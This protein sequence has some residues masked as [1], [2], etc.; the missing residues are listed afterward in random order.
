LKASP[1]MSAEQKIKMATAAVEKSIAEYERRIKENDLHRSKKRDGVPETPEL[2]ALRERR[3]DLRETVRQMKGGQ[4]QE[5]SRAGRFGPFI[6]RMSKAALTIWSEDLKTG[7][8]R[9]NPETS[10]TYRGSR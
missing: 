6:R 7:D 3:D 2:K 8:S 4:T 5:I 1:K 10:C 9:P